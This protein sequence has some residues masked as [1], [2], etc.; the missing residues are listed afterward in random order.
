MTSAQETASPTKRPAEDEAPEAVE[1]K[2]VKADDVEAPSTEEKKTEKVA[3]SAPEP[4]AE[5]EVE[6]DDEDVGGELAHLDTG[7][8]IEGR[9]TRGKKI[10]YSKLEVDEDDEDEEDED[11][12]E[13]VEGAEDGP[14]ESD[15][16]EDDEE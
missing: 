10:D 13:P 15:D 11:A 6:E 2:K 16:E 12:P 14:E 5:P 7:N 8:I 4:E 1:A 9:R 3:E